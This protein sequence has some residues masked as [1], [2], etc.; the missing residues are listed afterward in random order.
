MLKKVVDSGK[1][2]EKFAEFVKA[3]GGDP[4]A[5]YDVSLLPKASLVQEIPS[6]KTGY[7]SAITCDEIGICCLMLGGGRE[8]KESEID[9]SVGFE[10]RKKVGDFVKEGEVLAIMHANDEKKASAAMERFLRAYSFSEEAPSER[11]LI[12]GIL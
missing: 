6:T 2:L 7:V 12:K 9:L 3:Q 11:K 10:I 5:V 4:A 8:T 1:A